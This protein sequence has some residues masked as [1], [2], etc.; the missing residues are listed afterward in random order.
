MNGRYVISDYNLQKVYSIDINV[1]RIGS[2]NSYGDMASSNVTLSPDFITNVLNSGTSVTLQA[3]NDIT[4]NND[5]IV[6][7][8]YGNGGTLTFQAGRSI[9][10]NADIFTDNGD[11]NL[12]ANEDLATGVV[13]AQRDAG[14]A[15][16]SMAAG[17]SIDAG[18]GNVNI[19]LDDGTGKT[20]N[21]A[22]DISLRD[23][24]AN[25]ILVQNKNST[26]DVV[27][28]SGTL[29]ADATG[30]AITIASARNFVNNA[31]ASALDASNGRWLVYSTNP[32]SDVIGGLV[33]GFRRFSCVYGGSCPTL[34]TGNG[35]LYSYTPTL[36]IT[37]DA[38][39]AITYGDAVPSLTGYGYSVS[40]YWSL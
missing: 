38:I 28:Q 9:L 15:V 27:L 11:L 2:Y 39:T 26:G 8:N 24:S 21:A 18:T 31:G 5:L 14:A 37:P 25:T 29:S 36:T 19:R 13:N 12:Y 40:G 16:I 34:G 10:L 1:P 7:N 20:N 30:D 17:A 35:L 4:L 22:G 6:A 33:A 23:I 3:N 32:S